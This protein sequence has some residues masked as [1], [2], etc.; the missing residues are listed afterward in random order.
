[1]SDF[2][3]RLGRLHAP[4]KRDHLMRMIMTPAPV[5]LPPYK[6][7]PEGKVL[8]QG[9]TPQCV[10]FA[11]TGWELCAPV[12]D[13]AKDV[14]DPAVIYAEAQKVDEWASEAHDGTSVRAGMK[15]ML[16][17]GRTTEYVFETDMTMI[18]QWILTRGPVVFGTNWYEESMQAG[19][20]NFIRLNGPVVGGHAYLVDGYS[21]RYQAFRCKNSWGPTWGQHGYFWLHR[22][23]ARRLIEEDGEAAA[24]VEIK[25]S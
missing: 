16:A 6:F 12:M 20:D 2:D 3:P 13:R 15:V 19:P 21:D 10:A 25:P 24:A 17:Q 9:S 14:S 11:I 23:D 8:D 22:D 4:D 18:A 1:M 7:W 5:P